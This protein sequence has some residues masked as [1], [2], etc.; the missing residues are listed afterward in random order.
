MAGLTALSLAGEGDLLT[1]LIRAAQ[2]GAIAVAAGSTLLTWCCLA[3]S[4][5]WNDV[6]ERL[7]P[8]ASR[9]E[10]WG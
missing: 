9:A 6:E 8:A 1:L 7:G 4:A 3:L 10:P 5:R 2:V